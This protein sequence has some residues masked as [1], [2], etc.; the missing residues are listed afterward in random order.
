MIASRLVVTLL[1]GRFQC[2][3]N[4]I[5]V[6]VRMRVSSSHHVCQIP[7]RR[8]FLRPQWN[9]HITNYNHNFYGNAALS[10]E[11]PIKGSEV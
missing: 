8:H 2:D 3:C 10:S 11:G 6:I 7:E 5:L 9:R 4:H 1:N